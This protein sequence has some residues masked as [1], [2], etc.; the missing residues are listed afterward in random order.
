MTKTRLAAAPL[1]SIIFSSPMVL[2]LLSGQKTQTRR[3]VKPQPV[4]FSASV[5]TLPPSPEHLGKPW[6]PIGG[7]RQEN[8]RCP[9][10]K[11][12]DLLWVRE[13]FAAASHAR[14]LTPP[15]H[16]NRPSRKEADGT[17]FIPIYKATEP[18][19]HPVSDEGKPPEIRAKWTPAIYMPRWAS[20]ITLEITEVQ[21]ERLHDITEEDAKAE[22]A[23]PEFEMPASDFVAGSPTP[24][25]TFR[26]GFK[27][28]WK[29]INGL[30]SWEENPWVW[31]VKFR[32]H[33]A[34]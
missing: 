16:K 19:G 1:R 22:G 20:R 29:E 10:G 31:K 33:G 21:P 27:R 23:C 4:P 11:P 9:Y 34:A 25:P 14:G 8:W 17:V 6:M 7:V 2:A 30:S 24:S 32:R 12:G 5:S 18:E 13:T 26:V 15:L 3:V 28:L